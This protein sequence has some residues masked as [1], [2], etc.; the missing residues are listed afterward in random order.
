MRLIAALLCAAVCLPA[1]WRPVPEVD[2][3]KLT[4]AMFTDDELDLPYYLA[5]F[6]KVANAVVEEG[7]D[8]GFIRLSVWRAPKDNQPYNAR[9]MESIL[10]LAYF[11]ATNRPWNVYYGK[12]EVRDRLEAALDFWCRIQAPTGA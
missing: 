1:A 5:H 6:A 4:P 12:P 11:Y 7:P 2:W 8:R 10:S 3:S 9:I